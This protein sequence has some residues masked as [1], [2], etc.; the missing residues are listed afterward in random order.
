[1][2]R[3][4]RIVRNLLI[5]SRFPITIRDKKI[6]N[7]MK[8]KKLKVFLQKMDKKENSKGCFFNTGSL[9][10]SIYSY[11]I[12]NFKKTSNRSAPICLDSKWEWFETT[13][14]LLNPIRRLKTNFNALLHADV[15]FHTRKFLIHATR[16]TSTRWSLKY[17]SHAWFD[18][19]SEDSLIGDQLFRNLRNKKNFFFDWNE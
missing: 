14:P 3:T 13:W 7:W 4:W 15:N 16:G 11:M 1:M 17:K 9:K 10:S 8:W 18:I 19:Q 6:K 12:F 5:F 2:S